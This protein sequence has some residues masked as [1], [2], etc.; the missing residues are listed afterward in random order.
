M[1]YTIS[2]ENIFHVASPKLYTSTTNFDE[3]FK[4]IFETSEQVLF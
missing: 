3:I 1:F 2:Y 4:V